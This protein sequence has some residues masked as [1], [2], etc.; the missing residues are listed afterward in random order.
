MVPCD[1]SH[2]NPLPSPYRIPGSTPGGVSGQGG[3]LT[4]KS[5]VRSGLEVREFS[6]AYLLSVL[7]RV[8]FHSGEG[9]LRG[10]REE[11]Q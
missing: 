8:L 4:L 1:S 9:G 10:A 2:W 3:F 6:C 5:G 11:T 7:A